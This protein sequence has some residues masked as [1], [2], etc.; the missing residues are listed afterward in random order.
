[1]LVVVQNMLSSLI[2]SHLFDFTEG[3]IYVLGV[4]VAAGMVLARPLSLQS[5]AP[6]GSASASRSQP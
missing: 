4:G 2:N 5:Q 3:W 1:L 6:A